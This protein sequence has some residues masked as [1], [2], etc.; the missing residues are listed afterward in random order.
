MRVSTLSVKQKGE[1]LEAVIRFVQV[2]RSVTVRNDKKQYCDT[3]FSSLKIRTIDFN[4]TASSVG[5]DLIEGED[6]MKKAQIIEDRCHQYLHPPY[7]DVP[8][9]LATSIAAAAAAVLLCCWVCCLRWVKVQKSRKFA[10]LFYFYFSWPFLLTKKSRRDQEWKVRDP[11][12]VNFL[13][14]LKNEAEGSGP[15]VC[16]MK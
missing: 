16:E 11:S 13:G 1:E 12:G 15:F 3:W 8:N 7:D 14:F 6:I 2:R 5:E 9:C 10:F 4:F